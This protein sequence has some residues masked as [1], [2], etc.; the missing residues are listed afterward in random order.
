MDAAQ[1]HGHVPVDQITQARIGV[2]IVVRPRNALEV[3]EHI[4][5]TGGQQQIAQQLM[6][7]R[8]RH[9]RLQ[10]AGRP[11]Q[12]RLLDRSLDV[13]AKRGQ[14]GDV[15]QQVGA[16]IDTRYRFQT[17]IV[18]ILVQITDINL[19]ID[20]TAEFDGRAG[21]DLVTLGVAVITG[22]VPRALII[23]VVERRL[24][25]GV[26]ALGDL[27]ADPRG[28]RI[29]G[30][31][32]AGFGDDRAGTGLAVAVVI[33]LG[34]G[35]H[36]GAKNAGFMHITGGQG[37]QLILDGVLLVGHRIRRGPILV[38]KLVTGRPGEIDVALDVITPVQRDIAVADVLADFLGITFD[39]ATGDQIQRVTV[40]VG[41]DRD[42]GPQGG[43]VIAFGIVGGDID[44]GVIGLVHFHRRQDDEGTGLEPQGIV[45]GARTLQHALTFGGRRLRRL[46]PRLYLC[47]GT[48]QRQQAQGQGNPAKSLH[49]HL[50]RPPSET[51]YAMETTQPPARHPD[52]G[53]P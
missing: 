12:G 25:E 29:N 48:P 5:E 18:V 23:A 42:I 22:V 15:P 47:V 45:I 8:R 40:P 31:I 50:N 46:R 20:Q 53:T 28:H 34:P 16:I 4:A 32:A 3:L 17:G 26:I 43:H 14:F 51:D 2:V 27:V 21:I 13:Q 19:A 52:K 36:P 11:G 37:P 39:L 9:R 6:L 30:V 7:D 49:V 41:I 33:G 44:V 24:D 38:Q 10:I 35:I 1:P